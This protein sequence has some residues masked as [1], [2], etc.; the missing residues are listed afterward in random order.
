MDTAIR[1][2]A[3]DNIGKASILLSLSNLLLILLRKIIKTKSGGHFKSSIFYNKSYIVSHN[4]AFCV[5]ETTWLAQNEH[6]F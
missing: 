1:F 2:F 5:V 6:F 4:D 3:S